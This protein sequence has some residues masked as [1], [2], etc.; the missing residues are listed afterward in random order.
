MFGYLTERLVLSTLAKAALL[1]QWANRPAVCQNRSHKTEDEKLA[2]LCT[3]ALWSSVRESVSTRLPSVPQG[4]LEKGRLIYNDPLIVEEVNAPEVHDTDENWRERG[5]IATGDS[6]TEHFGNAKSPGDPVRGLYEMLGV[7]ETPFAI[8]MP[9]VIKRSPTNGRHMPVT[10][11]STLLPFSGTPTELVTEILLCCCGDYFNADN[12]FANDGVHKTLFIKHRST[13]RQVL[14][15]WCQII[16]RTAAFWMSHELTPTQGHSAFQFMTA[17]FSGAAL[18][19]CLL[20]LINIEPVWTAGRSDKLQPT[21]QFLK[22]GGPGMLHL[23]LV[24]FGLSMRNNSDLDKTATPTID[25]LYKVLREATSLEAL[26]IGQWIERRGPLN[27]D[28][29]LKLHFSP[30]G[31]DAFEQL[32]QL[33]RAPELN[34][35]DIRLMCEPDCTALLKCEELLRTVTDLRIYGVFKG[36]LGFLGL[37]TIMPGVTMLDVTTADRVL[38]RCVGMTGFKWTK[39]NLLRLRIPRIES[40]QS[41]LSA[42]TVANLHIHYPYPMKGLSYAGKQWVSSRVEHMVLTV[43]GEEAWYATAH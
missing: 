17:K 5:L 24:G 41:I 15:S 22:L 34:R 4:V 36:E 37:S 1:N 23:R 42:A 10:N 12:P 39:V 19:I 9:P 38:A 43:E 33:M 7:D 14:T 6:I 32:L 27:P 35:L 28:R 40:I 29:L 21:P 18:H 11:P 2:S 8:E 3:W 30:G 25:E 20:A 13:C 31:N 16:D 26:S